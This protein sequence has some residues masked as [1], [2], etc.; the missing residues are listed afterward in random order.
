MED[1]LHILDHIRSGELEA[2]KSLQG[3]EPTFPKG[4]DPYLHIPW[5]LHAIT[6]GAPATIKWMLEQNVALDFRD[7]TGDT[8]LHAAI[9]RDKDDKYEVLRMLIEAGADINMKGTNDW[10]PTHLAAV[11][12]DIEALTALVNHGADL[13]IKT[14]IDNYATPLEEAMVLNKYNDCSD[15]IAYLQSLQKE[16]A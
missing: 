1:Y 10:T 6:E 15:A 2:L 3:L 4:V 16:K 5:I 11:R 9:D 8:V 12:N 7:S 14:A 13:S